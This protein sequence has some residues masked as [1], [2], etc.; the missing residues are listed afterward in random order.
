MMRSDKLFNGATALVLVVAFGL[1]LSTVYLVADV[2]W[3]IL[4]RLAGR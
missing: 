3:A 1:A 2:V 4:F